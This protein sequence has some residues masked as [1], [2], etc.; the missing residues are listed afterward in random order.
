MASLTDAEAEEVGKDWARKTSI[1]FR[2]GDGDSVKTDKVDTKA[3]FLAIR[4]WMDEYRASYNAALPD[5]ARTTW[6]QREKAMALQR[7]VSA[8]YLAEG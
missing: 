3:A 7:V 2:A 6:T 1:R 4:D 8:E 5:A